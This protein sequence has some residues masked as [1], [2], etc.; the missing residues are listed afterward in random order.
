MADTLQTWTPWIVGAWLVLLFGIER[1]RPL[2]RP[3][4]PLMGRLGLNALAVALALGVGAVTVAP[5]IAGMLDWTRDARFGLL[6]VAGLPP[7]LSLP[8]GILLLDLSFYWWH[9]LNHA[10]PLLWRFHNVHHIDP[11]LDSTTAF[12]FHAGEIA[13]STAF[14][15]VQIG[16]I[17]PSALTIAVYELLFLTGTVFHHS[18]VRLPVSLERA[19]NLVFVTPR[20][21]GIHHSVIRDET[22]SNYSVVFR[23]WDMLH[24]SLC[25]NVPQEKIR[26]GVAGYTGSEDNSVLSVLL[27]PFRRQREYWR[28]P[29]GRQSRVRTGWDPDRRGRL[30]E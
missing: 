11:D 20:M 18:S 3:T 17:G 22:N 27:L 7:L 4:R 21:H 19:L 8:A 30:A 23:W 14:R 2:R 24:R 15:V 10:W 12:R 1:V 16:L 5:T 6:R 28:T 29:Q 25:L 26:I 13:Y 9:R